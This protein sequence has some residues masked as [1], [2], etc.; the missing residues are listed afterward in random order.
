MYMKPNNVLN[1][2]QACRN[3]WKDMAELPVNTYVTW[4]LENV[5]R[6]I[7]STSMEALESRNQKTGA[8][9]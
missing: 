7:I 1:K 5:K 2:S 6:G 8:A 9:D 3:V 4:K